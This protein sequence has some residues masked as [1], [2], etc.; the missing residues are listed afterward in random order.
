MR[1]FLLLSL[2]ITFP[3]VCAGWSD[4]EDTVERREPTHRQTR[5]VA[6]EIRIERPVLQS[7]GRMTETII[8]VNGRVRKC[9]EYGC[10]RNASSI[11]YTAITGLVVGYCQDHYQ[12]ATHVESDDHAQ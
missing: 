3:P 12:H 4:T 10:H 1:R 8:T 9:A 7:D 2:L 11:F 5:Y 6:S